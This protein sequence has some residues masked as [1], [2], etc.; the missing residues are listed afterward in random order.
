MSETTIKPLGT[1]VLIRPL[2][3]N[4]TRT[5][6]GIYIPETAKE[7]PQTGEV[8]AIGDEEEDIPVKVG[9][10]VLFPKYTGTEFKIDG[11]EHLIMEAS[12]L[13]AVIE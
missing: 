10:K 6:A 2:E 12:D 11:V 8:I 1:R 13:L 5:T 4:T 9:Q 7:K 3:E